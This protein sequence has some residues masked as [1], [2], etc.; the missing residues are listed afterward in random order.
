MGI[1]AAL[2]A[3]IGVILAVLWRMQAAAHA[4]REIAEAASEVRGLFR[5]WSWRRKANV[6]PIDLIDDPREAAAVLMAAVAQ[7]DA[8]LSE[9]ERTV[10]LME[11]TRRFGATGEQAEELLARA[12]WIVKDTTDPAA[13]MRRLTRL[14]QEKLGH[15]ERAELVAMLEAVASADGCADEAVARDIRRFAQSLAA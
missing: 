10:M 7:A 8:A 12:R 1:L 2:G 5:S 4:T 14:V 15:K 11:M 6:D 9:R 13:P 3:A